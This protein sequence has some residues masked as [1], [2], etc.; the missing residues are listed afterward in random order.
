MNKI[1]LI[2]GVFFFTYVSASPEVKGT[3]E[4]VEQYLA[5]I[6][7]I[8]TISRSSEKVVTSE[9]ARIKLLIKTDSKNLSDALKKNRSIRAKAKEKIINFGIKQSNI[10]ESKFSSTPEFGLFSDQP[11]SYLV[12]NI[13]TIIIESEEQFIS[14]ASIADTNDQIKFVSAKPII[15]SDNLIYNELTQNALSEVKQEASMYESMLGVKLTPVFFDENLSSFTDQNNA[16]NR[17]PIQKTMSSSYVKI[18]HSFEES[19]FKVTVIVKFKVLDK[20]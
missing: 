2:L 1:I 7:K 9:K 3:P 12:S 19:N 4:E 20:Q 10:S 5:G 15:L 13:I 14:V 17:K 18:N 11:K 8:V 16:L 6:P